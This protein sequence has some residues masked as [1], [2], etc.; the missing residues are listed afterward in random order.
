FHQFIAAA[1]ENV[2][3]DGGI[4]SFDGK[5]DEV[6]G[7][8]GRAAHGIDIA[9]GIGHG[10]LA[11]SVWVVNKGGEEINGLDDGQVFGQLIDTGIIQAFHA[12]DYIRVG[13]QGQIR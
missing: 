10:N 1:A 13:K 9:Q 7:G 11:E 6:H 2:L 5:T 4:H 8:Y 3:Q 12:P